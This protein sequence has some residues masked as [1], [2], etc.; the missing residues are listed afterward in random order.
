MASN[1]RVFKCSK[2]TAPESIV[3]TPLSSLSMI[4]WRSDNL[5]H[6]MSTERPVVPPGE[7]S[8]VENSHLKSIA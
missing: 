8:R 6:R 7:E 2:A 1:I 5:S 3:S 4:A